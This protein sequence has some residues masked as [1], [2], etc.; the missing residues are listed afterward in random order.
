MIMSPKQRLIICCICVIA[1]MVPVHATEIDTSPVLKTYVSSA[2]ADD[3]R[4]FEQVANLITPYSGRSIPT[5]MDVLPIQTFSLAGSSYNVE[6]WQ[7]AQDFLLFF[8]YIG[9]ASEAYQQYLDAGQGGVAPINR[10][11][12]YNNAHQHYLMAKELY[13]QCQGC[14]TYIPDF[15]M[16]SFPRRG[17]QVTEEETNTQAQ[18]MLLKPSNPRQPYDDEQFG[19]LADLWFY[20]YLLDE[21][22]AG[23]IAGDPRGADPSVRILRGDGPEQAQQ[24]YAAALE[25]NFSPEIHAYVS[26]LVLFFHA[27]AQAGPEFAAFESEKVLPT[28]MT[29][30]KPEYSRSAGW[31]Q[32]AQ[33]AL[34]KTELTKQGVTLPPFISF[35]EAFALP[36]GYEPTFASA[37]TPFLLTDEA[38][39]QGF[40]LFG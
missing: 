12:I 7:T 17:A 28:T 16:F 23:Y 26:E 34:K 33:A 29:K 20:L 25:M 10:E 36:R 35:E 32:E 14:S 15:V 6:D 8:Y 18:P 30:G 40:S 11:E 38:R 31:Y 24:L 5:G 21:I 3:T 22:E 4:F 37:L 2:F 27:I 1:L 9:R 39:G 19:S 13:Q